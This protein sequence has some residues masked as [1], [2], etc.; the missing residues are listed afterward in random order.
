M[1]GYEATRRLKADPALRSV[2]I[3]AIT[4]YALGQD[5]KPGRAPRGATTLS[6][7]HTARAIC[8]RRFANA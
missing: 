4:S 5:E 8:W 2:P 6:P 3:I 7:S 1:D